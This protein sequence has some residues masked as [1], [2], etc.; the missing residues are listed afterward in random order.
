MLTQNLPD[1]WEQF[2]MEKKAYW[3]LK[4]ATP[5]LQEFFTHPS[6]PASGNVLIPGAAFGY[7]A[8]AWALRG[9]Q[10]LAVDFSPTAVDELDRLSRKH[11]NFK[12]L[13]LDL[14]EL[15]PKDPKKGGA[16]FDIIYDYCTF[17]AIHP[18]RRDEYLEVWYKMLKDDGI[19]IAGTLLINLNFEGL[20]YGYVMMGVVSFSVD[21]VLS[22]QKQSAQL[23]IFTDKH[24]EVAKE[25][26]TLFRRGVTVV[27]CVGWY[28]KQP[29]KI[30][31]I[32]VRKSEA[33]DILKIAKRTD[34]RAFMTMNTVMG[35]FGQ[36]FEEVKGVK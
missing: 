16:Q 23:F 9:H 17:S 15:S 14:F 34:P 4:K 24:E 32:V 25:I 31:I 8:E 35:V 18:G 11:K 21:F 2:Y 33:M 26:T 3:D 36:G 30:V 10:V 19:I 13:D 29:K 20:M 12:S 7:D 1:F 5:A 22:G 28:S 27:D 6:C